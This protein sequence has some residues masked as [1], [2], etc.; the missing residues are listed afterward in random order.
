VQAP[1]EEESDDKKES[2]YEEVEQLY[3]IIF[4]SNM[5]ILL[6]N[7]NAKVGGENIFKPAKR[8]ERLHHDNGVRI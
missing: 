4:L 2:F 8:N 1:S 7:F 3:F 5:N 6:G